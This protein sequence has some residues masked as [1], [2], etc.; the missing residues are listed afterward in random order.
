MSRAL[1]TYSH[2]WA[3]TQR[4]HA[5][6][7]TYALNDHRPAS[8]CAGTHARPHGDEPTQ[9]MCDQGGGVS[10]S[11]WHATWDARVRQGPWPA[12][13]LACPRVAVL[14]GRDRL[15]A[16]S[17]AE[18]GIRVGWGMQPHRTYL[19]LRRVLLMHKT[20][21][22]IARATTR[23]SRG[24]RWPAHAARRARVV[25]HA[26]ALQGPAAWRPRSRTT[27]HWR[28]LRRRGTSAPTHITAHTH[29]PYPLPCFLTFSPPCPPGLQIAVKPE[30]TNADGKPDTRCGTWHVAYVCT[31]VP[32]NLH[33]SAAGDTGAFPEDHCCYL[34][35]SSVIR[36]QTPQQ[37]CRTLSSRDDTVQCTGVLCKAHPRKT[38]VSTV[39][40]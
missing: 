3:T 11:T 24:L 16:P 6:H 22:R 26:P 40:R 5:F 37:H 18:Y 2:T 8:C 34:R 20:C 33:V 36:Q 39:Y 27:R 17:D 23:A 12:K 9:I 29:H 4:L 38:V 13:R 31:C 1:Q 30:S 10:V 25:L 14:E 32:A 35:R 28:A 15:H 7:C 19:R 21:M